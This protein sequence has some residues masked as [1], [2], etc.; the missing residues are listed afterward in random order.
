MRNKKFFTQNDFFIQDVI[1]LLVNIIKILVLT[2]ILYE[3]GMPSDICLPLGKAII[4]VEAVYCIGN[5][6]LR[7]AADKDFDE[8]IKK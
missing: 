7:Y 1:H 4:I 2:G 6:V 3:L 8:N 5:M